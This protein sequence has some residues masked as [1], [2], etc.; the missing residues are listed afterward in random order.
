MCKRLCKFWLFPGPVQAS[1]RPPEQLCESPLFLKRLVR[2]G[3]SGGIHPVKAREA[4]V[5]GATS[6]VIEDDQAAA[7][8]TARLLLPAPGTPF[9]NPCDLYTSHRPQDLQRDEQSHEPSK[10]IPCTTWAGGRGEG[11]CRP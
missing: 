1:K 5:D 3:N 11:R 4:S 8:G 9:A 7:T 10:S 2:F 6:D